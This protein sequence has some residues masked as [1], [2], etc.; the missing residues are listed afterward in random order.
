MEKFTCTVKL[1]PYGLSQLYKYLEDHR[2]DIIEFVNDFGDLRE[3]YF[4]IVENCTE[5]GE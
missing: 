2:N 1:T 5:N 3:V 4:N